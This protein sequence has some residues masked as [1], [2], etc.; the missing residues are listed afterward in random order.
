MISFQ[1][2]VT[3]AFQTYIAPTLKISQEKVV[4]FFATL[5]KNEAYVKFQEYF[6]KFV[7]STQKQALSAIDWVTKNVQQI[8]S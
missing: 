8:I 5:E 4:N 6:L 2:N 3:K 7:H 1:Q